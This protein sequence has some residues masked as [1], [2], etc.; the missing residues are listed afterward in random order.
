[1]STAIVIIV[2]Q[3]S[4]AVILLLVVRTFGAFAREVRRV[5]D[6]NLLIQID[7]QRTTDTLV[8]LQADLLTRARESA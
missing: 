8:R 4:I 6:R 7:N 1:M 3:G 5:A 2:L